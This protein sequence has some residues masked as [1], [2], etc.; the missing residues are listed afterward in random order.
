MVTMNIVY[1]HIYILLIKTLT[2]YSA[3]HERSFWDVNFFFFDFF[4]LMDQVELRSAMQKT[5][6]SPNVFTWKNTVFSES[7]SS[8]LCSSQKKNTCHFIC[9]ALLLWILENASCRFF[10]RHFAFHATVQSSKKWTNIMFG[11][12]EPPIHNPNN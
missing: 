6:S 11:Q 2:S 10:G 3:F 7:P 5:Q 8:H 12:S 4:F 1:H 9:E